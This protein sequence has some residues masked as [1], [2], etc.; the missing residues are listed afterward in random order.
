MIHEGFNDLSTPKVPFAVHGHINIPWIHIRST[1]PRSQ[2][3]EQVLFH[4]IIVTATAPAAAAAPLPP[5]S[6]IIATM[7]GRTNDGDR[8]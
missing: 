6:V 7:K 1:Q 4:S 8:T 2:C 5:R 3:N